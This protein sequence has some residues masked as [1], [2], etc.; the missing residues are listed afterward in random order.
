MSLAAVAALLEL[1]AI[2]CLALLLA[3]AKE[4]CARARAEAHGGGS[5]DAGR[6]R[7]RHLSPHRA[8]I[9]R[10]KGKE[11]ARGRR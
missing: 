7:T 9:E 4:R 10:L 3:A 2:L 5:A 11:T 8:A 1:P 6:T